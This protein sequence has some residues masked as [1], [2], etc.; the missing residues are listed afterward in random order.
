MQT[1]E[2]HAPRRPLGMYRAVFFRT[3]AT[4][5]PFAGPLTAVFARV[6]KEMIA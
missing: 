1:H 2:Q 5:E 3:A 6:G 4:G